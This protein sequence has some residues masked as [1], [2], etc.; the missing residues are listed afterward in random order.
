M[1]RRLF[2]SVLCFLSIQT[3]AYDFKSGD[4]CYNITSA[5]NVEVARGSYSAL[6]SVTIPDKVTFEGAT[7]SVTGIGT[8]AFFSC[9]ELTSI[10][11]PN[12]LEVI[13]PQAF[14]ECNGLTSVVIP[15]SVTTIDNA[16]SNCK[17]L[18]SVTIMGDKISN[19]GVFGFGCPKLKFNS[20]GNADY[21][22][23]AD[24]PYL[25]LV[26]ATATDIKECS[27]NERTRSIATMA[28]DKCK[29]LTSIAIP[30]TVT[31]IGDCAFQ[32]SGL[33]SVDIPNSVTSLGSGAFNACYDLK[34]VWIPKSVERIGEG[35]FRL[36]PNVVV[37]CESERPGLLWNKDWRNGGLDM[38]N[39][40]GKIVWKAEKK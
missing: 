8:S 17:N 24:N 39:I 6:T 15:G 22:G 27:I 37:K 14:D 11:L 35:A 23:N 1:I 2:V 16:F 10:T 18:E 20:F 40:G 36:C 19:V 13:C 7:Y 4:L 21:L 32:G 26:M 31:C 38:I 30:N 34:E 33:V 28:F 12:T 3:F 25:V 9:E 5:Y 29:E